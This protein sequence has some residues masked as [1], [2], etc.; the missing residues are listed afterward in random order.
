MTPTLSCWR[1][2]RWLSERGSELPNGDGP[3]A[4]TGAPLLGYSWAYR[5]D[6]K[7]Y[8]GGHDGGSNPASTVSCSNPR[9]VGLEYAHSGPCNTEGSRADALL[10][11]R[12]QDYDDP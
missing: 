2:G 1:R 11:S 5:K 3:G 7:A 6:G 4:A 10:A 8:A 9:C 12:R